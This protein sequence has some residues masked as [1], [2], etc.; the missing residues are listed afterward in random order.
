M[1][2]ITRW[3]VFF[4]CNFGEAGEVGT[5]TAQM[6]ECFTGVVQGAD[7]QYL[8]FIASL[9]FWELSDEMSALWHFFHRV[10][11]LQALRRQVLSQVNTHG[12]TYSLY[13]DI[14][15]GVPH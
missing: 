13:D 10:Q 3:S 2:F 11:H 8:F 15:I 9:F 14:C 4:V 12:V 5:A 6:S 1:A 7:D